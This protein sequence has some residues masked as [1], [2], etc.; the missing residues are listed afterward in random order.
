MFLQLLSYEFS[1]KMMCSGYWEQFRLKVIVEA[2]RHYH[3]KCLKA[4]Q[5][6]EPLHRT[7]SFNVQERGMAREEVAGPLCLV[8]PQ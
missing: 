4:G 5:G 3:Q 6:L 1:Q 8:Q 7:R 2:I